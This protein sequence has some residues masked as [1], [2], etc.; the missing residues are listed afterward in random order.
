MITQLQLLWLLARAGLQSI[1]CARGAWEHGRD[2]R[3]YGCVRCT[4]DSCGRHHRDEG[5]REG[6]FCDFELT[7]KWSGSFQ[8]IRASDRTNSH[9][10]SRWT[11]CGSAVVEVV[12]VLPVMMLIILLSIQAALWAEAAEVVQGAAAIG[13][14]TAAGS[15][16]STAAGVAAT[17]SY[18]LVHG[19]HLVTRPSVSMSTSPR[20]VVE[21]RVDASAISIIPFLHLSVSAVRSEPLQKF[22]ES[23]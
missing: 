15:G 11:D 9:G 14:E 4:S 10:C 18:L 23:G 21:V 19:G 12:I 8:L 2:G 6:T 20:G 16:S 7:R 17:N 1:P 5:H 3:P 22:R 13:S